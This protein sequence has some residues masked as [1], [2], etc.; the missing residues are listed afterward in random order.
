MRGSRGG[1]RPPARAPRSGI[2]CRHRR[3]CQASGRAPHIPQSGGIRLRRIRARTRRRESIHRR[4]IYS[5]LATHSLRFG[6][7]P[8]RTLASP[9]RCPPRLRRCRPLT[10]GPLIGLCQCKRS[11][12][13][14]LRKEMAAP[15]TCGKAGI[16]PTRIH[17]LPHPQTSILKCTTA[18]TLMVAE[19]AERDTAIIQ[20]PPSSKTMQVN[21]DIQIGNIRMTKVIH[22]DLPLQVSR[23]IRTN[24]ITLNRTQTPGF[25]S[26]KLYGVEQGTVRLTNLE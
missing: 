10:H 3:R 6:V 22:L 18:T 16:R 15:E 9:C 1:S 8:M 5:T 12:R 7:R 21:I 13:T 2:G 11:P 26:P 23:N 19:L 14:S 17:P 24:S 20:G 25:L 4:D